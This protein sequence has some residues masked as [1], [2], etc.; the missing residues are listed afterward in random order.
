M[1]RGSNFAGTSPQ[2]QDDPGRTSRGVRPGRLVHVL[3]RETLHNSNNSK[4]KYGRSPTTGAVAP[5]LQPIG[6]TDCRPPHHLHSTG[7][8]SRQL[9]RRD[10][11][12]QLLPKPTHR[13]K[14]SIMITIPPFPEDRLRDPQ[15]QAEL[16]IYREFEVSEAPGTVIYE[17]KA[18]RRSPE[19]DFAIWIEG[20]G[21][22]AMQVKGGIYRVEGGSW[23]LNT[24]QGE[25]RKPS[26]LAQLWDST[27]KLH[28]NLKEQVK[29]NRNPFFVAV[30][31]FPDM[32]PDGDIEEWARAHQR[33]CRFRDRAPSGEADRTGPAHQV[34]VSTNHLRDRRG[35]GS[36]FAQAGTGTNGLGQDPSTSGR[37]PACRSGDHLRDRRGSGSGIVQARHR[38]QRSRTRSKH[39]GS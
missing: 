15:R 33:A 22:Y 32:E 7:R 38:H 3:R 12:G 14:E 17:A 5:R 36:G 28:D 39:V 1:N 29:D 30:L 11:D 19:V 34:A 2:P 18:S 35:G 10:R 23:F 13:R 8:R 16:A 24:P 20:V 6:S 31:S 37:D 27:M 4:E 21:R 25:I 9:G 26:P